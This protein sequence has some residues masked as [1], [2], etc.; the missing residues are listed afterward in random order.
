MALIGR[1]H[2][3][4][5][6]KQPPQLLLDVHGVGYEIEAPMSTFYSLPPV[7][8]ET[9]LHTHLSIRE[10]AHVLFG[11]ATEAERK[12]FR[13]LIKVNGVGPKLALGVLSGMPVEQF[14]R[15]IEDGD[16][17]TL[18]RL[19]G[20][21][22]K[23][24]ERLLVEMRDRLRDFDNPVAL[25]GMVSAAPITRSGAEADAISALIALGY[26]PNEA[27]KA[28]EGIETSSLTSEEIIRRALQ[29]MVRK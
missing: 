1:L 25:P 24:A 12:L 11:F 16:A 26:K 8:S 21:G 27:A 17:T 23:T 7:G 20:V 9:I 5:V 3:K 6:A 28:I 22:K 15:C 4:L 18:T 2:G 10:D 19:P 13:V 14:V 29:K